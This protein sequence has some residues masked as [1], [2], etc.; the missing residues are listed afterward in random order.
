VNYKVWFDEDNDILRMEVLGELVKKDVDELFPAMGKMLEGKERRY[1]LVDLSS[2]DRPASFSKDVRK[3]YKE[4]AD[5]VK[6]DKA[7]LV[8]AKP[9]TRMVAKTVL[10]ITGSAKSTQFFKTVD[11]AL[12]W[13]DEDE[14]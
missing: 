13:F 8:G 12:K 9:V 1:I 5:L 6:A 11:E 7:A 10:A 3:A 4:N 2:D 14:Q